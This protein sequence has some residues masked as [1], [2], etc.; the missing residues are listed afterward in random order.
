M[1]LITYFYN[2]KKKQKIIHINSY[3]NL[4]INI[5]N[6]IDDLQYFLKNSQF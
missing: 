4:E 3:N 5:E 1:V 2:D 6:L